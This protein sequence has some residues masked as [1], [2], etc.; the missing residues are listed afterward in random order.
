MVVWAF[1]VILLIIQKLKENPSKAYHSEFIPLSD[2][3]DK[4]LLG[5]TESDEEDV[6]LTDVAINA[7]KEKIKVTKKQIA[8]KDQ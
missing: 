3:S 4:N 5:N 6:I 7:L 8:K 1:Y 2:K